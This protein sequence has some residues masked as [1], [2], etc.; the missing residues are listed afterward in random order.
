MEPDQPTPHVL[1]INFQLHPGVKV[2]PI[3]G[4]FRRRLNLSSGKGT[5][6]FWPEI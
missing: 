6:I 5:I 3:G 2:L 1:M 4:E